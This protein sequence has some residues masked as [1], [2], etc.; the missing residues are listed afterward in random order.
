MCNEVVVAYFLVLSQHLY[1]GTERIYEKSQQD[2]HP[3]GR[4]SNWG[5]PDYKA[6]I[7]TTTL[8]ISALR[9]HVSSGILWEFHNETRAFVNASRRTGLF[10]VITDEMKKIMTNYLTFWYMAYSK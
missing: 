6:G 7:L 4:D 2:N 8:L 3:L 10:F 5:L 1:G 9:T